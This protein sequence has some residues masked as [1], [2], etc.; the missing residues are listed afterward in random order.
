MNHQ[1]KVSFKVIMKQRSKEKHPDCVE[2]IRLEVLEELFVPIVIENCRN[3]CTHVPLPNNLLK[4][5][6]YIKDFDQRIDGKWNPDP[7]TLCSIEQ[8]GL[9]DAEFI[10]TNYSFKPCSIEEFEGKLLE[11]EII[12]GMHDIFVW[13]ESFY[14]DVS[15]NNDIFFPSFNGPLHDSQIRTIKFSYTFERPEMATLLV[16]D[17]V[18]TFV[19]LVGIVGGTRDVHR[20]CLLR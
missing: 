16:E 18:V 5:C 4:L 9:A 10:K 15:H 11:D 1:T 17:F 7:D 2:K 3:P 20:L 12:D 14:K 19:D 13:K 6:D 8:K